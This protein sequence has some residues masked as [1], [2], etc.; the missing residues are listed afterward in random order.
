M[1]NRCP[2]VIYLHLALALSVLCGLAS[3]M[4]TAA[5]LD[6]SFELGLGIGSDDVS[7][8]VA[9]LNSVGKEG[10]GT[11]ASPT[12]SVTFG[13]PLDERGPRIVEMSC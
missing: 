11:V 4:R 10:G 13:K 8:D 12:S 9:L 5:E 3:G 6:D 1:V 2:I 7:L